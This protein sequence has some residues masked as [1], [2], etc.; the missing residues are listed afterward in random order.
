MGLNVHVGTRLVQN[1]MEDSQEVLHT[2]MLSV[3]VWKLLLRLQPQPRKNVNTR[4]CHDGIHTGHDSQDNR[5][6]YWR[7]LEGNSKQL[8]VQE[9]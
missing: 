1:M 6:A 7:K 2:G 9:S 3:D 5:V 8:L 4:S